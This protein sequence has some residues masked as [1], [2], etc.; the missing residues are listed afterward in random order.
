MRIL[1]FGMNGPF[2]RAVLG[3]LLENG[4]RPEAV[5]LSDREESG[6]RRLAPEASPSTNPLEVPLLDAYVEPGPLHLAWS[7]GIPVY[8]CGPLT[9]PPVQ[10]FVEAAAADVACV[11]CFDRKFPQAILDAPRLGVLNVHPSRLPAYRGPE[12]LFWQLRDDVNPMG[13]TVHWMDAGLDTGDLAAQGWITRPDGASWSQLES[14]AA[15]AGGDLLAQVLNALAQ[16]QLPR[17]PQ[18]AGGSYHPLPAPADFTLSPDWTAR[19][20]FNFMRG[21]AAWGF[22]FRLEIGGQRLQLRAA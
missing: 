20:A 4:W 18:P 7:Q 5:L 22:P 19:R 9:G 13:V 6:L 21:A 15:Q 2:T 10:A 12:P 3:Q 1:F 8:A 16:G 14:L 17:V 11:A